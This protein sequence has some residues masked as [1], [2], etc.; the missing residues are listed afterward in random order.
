VFVDLGDGED[1]ERSVAAFAQA[2]DAR[3]RAVVFSQ[4][5]WTTGAML[6]VARIAAAARDAGAAVIVDAAQSVGAIPVRPDEL[7]I[8]T[9]ALSAQKW[10]LGP[11]GMG[12]LVADPAVIERLIP[13]LGGHYTF[14][15]IDGRGE[16]A[17][18][19]DGRRFE[20]TGYHRPSVVGMARSIG[21]LSMYVGLDFVRRRGPALAANLAAR[22][23]AI[24]GVEVL[25]PPERMAT[26][27]TI[28]IA[29]WPAQLAL[30][31]LGGRAFAIARTITSL[32]AVRFSVGFF[33]SEEELDRLADTVELIASH[34]PE[35][36]PR[37]RVLA[38][39]DDT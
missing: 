5:L 31:E 6:P 2:L 35:S 7:G 32:D 38:M 26:L 24:P 10:L 30:D 29:G 33:N 27:V 39:L 9:L 15:R 13:A 21:W 14:E 8:D 34:T 23:A 37:R 28:R 1:D 17:W 4:V 36:I 3:T 22:L 18:W 11:E 12:A 25:T 16:A 19:G 20:A